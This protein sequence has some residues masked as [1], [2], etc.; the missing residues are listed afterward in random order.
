[1]AKTK[2]MALGG[3][4]GAANVALQSVK[5][6]P[7]TYAAPAGTP[8]ANMGGGTAGSPPASGGPMAFMSAIQQAAQAIPKSS[9]LPPGT[10]RGTVS[11]GRATPADIAAAQAR[12]GPSK[13]ASGP[14]RTMGGMGMKNG[15]TASSRADGCAT[16]GK[17]KGKFV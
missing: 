1:M 5:A 13:T 3:M 17:T 4:G 15:G 7:R 14:P 12:F 2:K 11:A 9:P 16:K 10:P 6:A 8:K